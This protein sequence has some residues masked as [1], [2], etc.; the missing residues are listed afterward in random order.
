[1]EEPFFGLVSEV[2]CSVA[3][4]YCKQNDYSFFAFYLHKVMTAI[5]EIENFRYRI[6]DG[7]VII[8]NEINASA[9]IS[10]PDTTFGF[11]FIKYNTD[12]EVFQYNVKAETE[13]VLQTSGLFTTEFPTDNVIHFSAVPW[14]KFTALSHCRSFSMP[15]SCP[16]ISVGKMTVSENGCRSMPIS[17]HAH[18]GLVDGYHIGLLLNRLQK[19]LNQF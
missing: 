12:F 15:D 18:H 1:M 11:S 8:Y 2:D 4:N 10:R 9:T 13:R 3:Y 5:N 6:K 14:V 16:K 7:K 17:I 19:L